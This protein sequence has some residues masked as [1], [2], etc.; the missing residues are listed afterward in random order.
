LS[1]VRQAVLWRESSYGT[2]SEAGS[3][4]VARILTVP[5]HLLDADDEDVVSAAEEALVVA[6]D[7]LDA[8]DDGDGDDIPF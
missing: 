7:A 8:R 4:F 1:L 2:D 5:S 6:D 3:T